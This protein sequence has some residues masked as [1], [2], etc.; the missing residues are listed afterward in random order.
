MTEPPRMLTHHGGQIFRS[1]VTQMDTEEGR[2]CGTRIATELALHLTSI[3][4]S[5]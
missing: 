4:S 3:G 1:S 5:H 2:S